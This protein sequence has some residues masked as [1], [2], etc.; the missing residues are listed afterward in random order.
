M[1]R[2]ALAQIVVNQV[3]SARDAVLA[4]SNIKSRHFFSS[5][6]TTV[7]LDNGYKTFTFPVPINSSKC[8]VIVHS[9]GVLNVQGASSAVFSNIEDLYVRIQST[10]SG[11]LVS[12]SFEVIEYV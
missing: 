6:G 2:D 11:S 4:K 3:A 1:A 10:G 9:L 8:S 12:Y 5:G 7:P